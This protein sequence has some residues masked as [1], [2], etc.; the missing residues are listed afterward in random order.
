[1]AT[2]RA[3]DAAVIRGSQTAKSD[4]DFHQRNFRDSPGG[5]GR[6]IDLEV[7]SVEAHR[8]VEIKTGS[9]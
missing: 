2:A 3:G 8:H 4:P 7:I 6:Q 5:E 9:A 1:L